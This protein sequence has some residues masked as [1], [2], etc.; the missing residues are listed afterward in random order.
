MADS[1]AT[2]VLE[3]SD[4]TVAFGERLVL[5]RASLGVSA[6]ELV[7][8]RGA[9]GS[10]KTTLLRVLAGVQM[11]DSGRVLYSGQEL[12]ALSDDA[13]SRLRLAEFGFIFQFA[14]LVPELTLWENIS[15]PLEFLGFGRKAR[16]ARVD[17]LVETV[18]LQDCCSQ[19]PHI[20]S[21]GERQR[22]AVARVS[23]SPES[24]V[25]R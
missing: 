16:V 19:L 6:S 14:D 18:G 17:S 2:H 4:L 11:P 25:R 1:S 5:S 20:V 13:R 22:A 10:G 23:A 12:T 7:A 21:G 3:A 8:I 9:S 15:L 24:G